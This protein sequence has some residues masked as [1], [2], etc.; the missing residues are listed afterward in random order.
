MD[1]G[2]RSSWGASLGAPTMRVLT[3]VSPRASPAATRTRP[4]QLVGPLGVALLTLVLLSWGDGRRPFPPQDRRGLLSGSGGSQVRWIAMQDMLG[5]P[6]AAG[7]RGSTPRRRYAPPPAHVMPHLRASS[8]HGMQEGD[9]VLS[10][11]QQGRPLPWRRASGTPLRTGGPL[12]AGAARQSVVPLAQRCAV[13]NNVAHHMDVAAGLA[14][15]FQVGAGC[16]LGRACSPEMWQTHVLDPRPAAVWYLDAART[17]VHA[18]RAGGRLPGDL[19]LSQGDPTP[20][21]KL[22]LL[23]GQAGCCRR[24]SGKPTLPPCCRAPSQ[25]P[26]L[27]IMLPAAGCDGRVVPGRLRHT[28][29]PAGD[30]RPGVWGRGA[31]LTP[32]GRVSCGPHHSGAQPPGCPLCCS[33][34]WWPWPPSQRRAPACRCSGS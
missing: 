14:W 16:W 30:C 21:G 6:Q 20:A 31:A 17:R 28:F 23:L 1:Y 33:L 22:S 12:L 27:C 5:S 18:L 24:G 10:Q 25:S 3:V 4:R 29:L 7:H 26:P 8:T 19:L 15:A 32:C 2:S 9:G 34:M 11:Q 13:F